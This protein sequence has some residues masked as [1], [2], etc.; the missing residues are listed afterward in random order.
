L[1]LASF[2]D[3]AEADVL[4]YMTFPAQHRAKL[5]ST[6]P[7]ERVNGEIKR[8]TEVVGARG[9]AD[10]R[11]LINRA[12]PTPM[13]VNANSV[14]RPSNAFTAAKSPL[15]QAP[16]TWAA[17]PPTEEFQPARAQRRS[18]EPGI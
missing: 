3:E 9:R 14:A 11:P 4:A 6:N 7:L 2:L 16:S 13:P 8:R 1:K 17:W 10:A 18:K 15:P 5:H 12:G